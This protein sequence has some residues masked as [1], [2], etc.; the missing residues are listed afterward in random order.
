MARRG[1]RLDQVVTEGLRPAIC[2][3]DLTGY[4]G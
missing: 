1:D 4:T 3:V 2:F